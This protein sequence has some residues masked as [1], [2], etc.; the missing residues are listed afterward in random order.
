MTLVVEVGGG[1]PAQAV[2]RTSNQYRDVTVRQT[3]RRRAATRAPGVGCA[4]WRARGRPAP[5]RAPRDVRTVG[6]G[7]A[8]RVAGAGTERAASGATER[9]R[10][11]SERRSLRGRRRAAPPRPSPARTKTTNLSSTH[12]DPPGT[13]SRRPG[14]AANYRRNLRLRLDTKIVILIILFVIR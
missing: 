13:A 10:R 12:A 7:A 11:C 2:T 8:A 9:G 5:T 4:Q 3:G 6:G 14:C 1:V